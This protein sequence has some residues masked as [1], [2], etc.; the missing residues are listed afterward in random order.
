[1]LQQMQIL[2]IFSTLITLLYI[3]LADL[4]LI[5]SALVNSEADCRLI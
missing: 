4:A 2:Q 1:M 5:P 3:L